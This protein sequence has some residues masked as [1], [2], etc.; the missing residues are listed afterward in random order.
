[1][2]FYYSETLLI[3][4]YP[5]IHLLQDHIGTNYNVPWD[6]YGYIITFKVYLIRESDKIKIGNIKMLSKVNENTS[7]YFKEY[8]Q[9]IEPKV[10]KIDDILSEKKLVS[11]GEDIDYYKKINLLFELEQIDSLLESLCDAGYFR[12]N[13]SDY[14]EWDGYSGSLMRG[15]S[16]AAILKK[17]Y[18]IAV[19]RYNPTT[20]FDLNIES[21]GDS[22]D[23]I[24][25]KFNLDRKLGKSNICLLIGKN[26]VGKTHILKKSVKL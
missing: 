19:G 6:D 11:I 9:E 5:G 4:K 16:S 25:F 12:D 13:Y 15:S 18:Q 26:G 20:K 8:G 2:N 24:N 21:L 22:F 7:I 17:G 14:S 3:D 23:P 1:M 10:I